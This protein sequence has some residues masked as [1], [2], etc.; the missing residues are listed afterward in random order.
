MGGRE[1]S[2]E[3]IR[4]VGEECEEELVRG[5][6]WVRGWKRKGSVWD[7]DVWALGRGRREGEV[8]QDVW[9]EQSWSRM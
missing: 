5:E 4:G 6:C 3:W 8:W 9:D 7:F 1:E 2:L